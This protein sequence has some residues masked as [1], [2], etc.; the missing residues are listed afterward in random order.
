MTLLLGTLADT[1]NV[2]R[3]H[4][5][6][7]SGDPEL[8]ARAFA[9]AILQLADRCVVGVPCERHFGSVHGREAEEL[10]AGVERILENTSTVRT[11]DA[12]FV[13]AELRKTLLRLLDHID[14]RD[15]LAFRE[16]DDVCCDDCSG[17]GFAQTETLPNASC[18]PCHGTGSVERRPSSCG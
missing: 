8:R 2:A 10:R 12:P 14:A 13:L 17:T 1:V 3:D 18:V 5:H 15:S 6:G 16:A 11:E 4:L 9:E 7:A